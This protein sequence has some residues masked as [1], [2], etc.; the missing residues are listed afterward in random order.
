MVN[1]Q[2]RPAQGACHLAKGVFRV[3]FGFGGAGSRALQQAEISGAGHRLGA[4][5]YVQLAIQAGGVGLDC[6]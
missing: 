2:Y 3:C 5:D 4:A 6:P 1:A